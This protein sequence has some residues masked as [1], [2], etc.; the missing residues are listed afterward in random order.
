MNGLI[1]IVR[2]ENSYLQQIKDTFAFNYVNRFKNDLVKMPSIYM[3]T[4]TKS[5]LTQMADLIRLR[6]TLQMVPKL[7]WVLIEDSEKKS[8]RIA[9]FL[10]E[11]GIK[12]HHMAVKSPW[13]TEPKR[14]TFYRGSIQRNMALKWIQSLKQNDITIYF[15]DDDNSYD[16]QL[17]EE[18]NIFI[19]TIF[20][21]NLKRLDIPKEFLF[22]Q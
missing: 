15:G 1:K 5:R 21:K 4:P 20:L 6:N 2:E 8:E 3:I 22:S 11:S 17:F 13:T 18:V 14:F 12:Y 7:Y 16:L 9:N 10:K 19:S